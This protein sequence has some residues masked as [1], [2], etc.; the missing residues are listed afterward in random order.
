MSQKQYFSYVRVSTQRQG[1]FG[2]SLAEQQSS[3]ERY[4]RTWNLK[5]VK[6]FEEQE[7]AAKQGRPVFLEMLKA[8]RQGK[9]SGLVIHKIDR[10]ARNLKDWADLGSLIDSGL[11]V[12]FANESLDLNTRGGRLSADIQAVVASDYIR[13]LREE[14]KKGFYG[15]LKQGFY[16]MPA[17]IGYVD[18][19]KAE[20]KRIDT[21]RAPLIRKAFELYSTGQVGLFAL[22]DKLFELGLRNKNGKK[23]TT[24]GLST[25]LHNSFYIGLI[26]IKKKGEIFAGRHTPMIPKALFD[27]VQTVLSGKYVKQTE[28]HFFRFRRHI[29]CTDCGKVL[30]AERQK[31]NVYYRCHTRNC[32]KGTLK[33]EEIDKEVLHTFEK[34][35]LD[36][37]EYAYFKKA[38]MT[39]TNNSLFDVKVKTKQLQLQSKQI[40]ARLSK[41]A[42][43]YVEGVFDQVTYTQKK[44]EMMFEELSVNEKISNVGRNNHEPANRLGALLEL[45]NTAYLSYEIGN[46][47]EKRNLVKM[48]T[49]NFEAEGKSVLVKLE[50][51]FQMIAERE[52]FSSGGPQRDTARTLR[53]LFKMLLQYFK[54]LDTSKSNNELLNYLISKTPKKIRNNNY[55]YLQK[56][57]PNIQL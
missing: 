28:R 45:V 34:L 3:I 26:K 39:A 1:Q 21:N 19:G 48:V 20:P 6:C 57:R 37:A 54:D 14:V 51:P 8:L 30:I 27:K 36:E 22:A 53:P 49:S 25:M 16:P 24:S 29:Y 4:C 2:T 13:N 9:A 31:G 41:L 15:R 56:S 35:R 44:N 43:A 47:V 11:E 5:I 7:T 17:P 12:H 32:F 23:V 10:G 50:T 38:A 52:S 40:K 33:E 42:D 55:Q 18:M 46:P